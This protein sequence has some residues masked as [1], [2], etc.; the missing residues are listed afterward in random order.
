[1]NCKT[2]YIKVTANTVILG[3]NNLRCANGPFTVICQRK[4]QTMIDTVVDS[5][6]S[7]SGLSVN[8]SFCL[9]FVIIAVTD[10]FSKLSILSDGVKDGHAIVKFHEKVVCNHNQPARRVNLL[11]RRARFMKPGRHFL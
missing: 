7:P 9:L 4:L 1:M 8:P 11:H 2:S 10:T 6:I 3:I 5:C